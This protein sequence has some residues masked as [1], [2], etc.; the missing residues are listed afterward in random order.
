MSNT[1]WVVVANGSRA[2][3]LERPAPSDALREIRVWDHPEMR[4]HGAPTHTAHRTSGTH[5]RSG[6]APPQ[7]NK[8]HLREQFADEIGDWLRHALN[9]QGQRPLAVI[10]SN[11]FLGALLSHGN[12]WLSR[13]VCAHHPLDLTG[14]PLAQLDERL[15]RE[16]RL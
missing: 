5:G 8:T 4:E 16:F 3:L 13:R 10:A 9:T 7:S 12:G 6:L 1:L 14:L 2:R 15:R 11:P